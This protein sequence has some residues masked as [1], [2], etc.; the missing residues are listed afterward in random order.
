MLYAMR[1]TEPIILKET[2]KAYFLEFRT[3]FGDIKG[4]FPKSVCLLNNEER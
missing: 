1:T 4:W 2:D 3:D